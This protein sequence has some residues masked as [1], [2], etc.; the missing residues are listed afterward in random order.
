MYQYSLLPPAHTYTD[1]RHQN[2]L[3]PSVLPQASFSL[4]EWD[5]GCWKWGIMSLVLQHYQMYVTCTV[6]V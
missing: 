6:T 1:Q 5:H 2:T 4:D 3:K